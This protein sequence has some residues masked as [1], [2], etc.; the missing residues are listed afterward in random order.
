MIGKYWVVDVT[1]V[2]NGLSLKQQIKDANCKIVEY[3][4]VLE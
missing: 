3:R 1:E 4:E 2:D